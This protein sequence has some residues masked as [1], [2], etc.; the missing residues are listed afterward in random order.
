MNKRALLELSIAHIPQLQCADR[1]RLAELLSSEQDL[2][3][4]ALID[5]ERM[6]GKSVSI[7]NWEPQS[8]VAA[9]SRAAELSV[10]RGIGILSYFSNSYPPLLREL[11]DAPLIMYFRGTLPDPEKPLVAIVGTR[12]PDAPAMKEALRFGLEFA[13]LGIPVIS[14]L[15][16]GIDAMA[17]RGNIEGGAPSLAVLGSGLDGIYPASN[18]GLARRIME[19]GGCLLSEYPVGMAP[20]KWHFPARNRIISVMARA[21]LVVEAPEHSGALISAQF[22]LD[23]GRDLWV[24]SSGMQ[25]ALGAGCRNLAEQGARTAKSA[26]EIVDDWIYNPDPVSKESG[27][28]QEFELQQE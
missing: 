2:L 3:H 20:K 28:K 12:R 23:Q 11:S 27:I 13:R 14:G 22:A 26:K 24:A 18:R 15:A 19:N 17:H 21:M 6:L 9:A 16:L 7:K 5:M 4:L 1:I 10:R 25:S 8:W